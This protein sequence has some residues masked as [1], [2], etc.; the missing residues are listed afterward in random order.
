MVLVFGS[1]GIGYTIFPFLASS[2]VGRI[3]VANHNYVEVYNL[4]RQVIHTE[5]RRGTSKA[6][7]A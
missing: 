2:D 3:T 1:G 4:R 7:S 6:R 5:G